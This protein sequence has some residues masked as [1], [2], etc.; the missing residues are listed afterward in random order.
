[1]KRLIIIL[2][3]LVHIITS[4]QN[5]FSDEIPIIE[6]DNQKYELVEVDNNGHALVKYTK[7]YADGSVE[8]DGYYLNGKVYGTWN[9]YDP[10]GKKV[11]TIKY[12]KD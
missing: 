12:N 10:R 11:H 2:V 3:M 5:V 4:A 8:Q 7:F 6:R 1:M 9:M